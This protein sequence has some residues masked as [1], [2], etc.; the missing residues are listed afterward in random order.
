MLEI[1]V[2]QLLASRPFTAVVFYPKLPNHLKPGPTR[3]GLTYQVE[4]DLTSHPVQVL[5]A[6]NFYAY[7]AKHAKILQ[8]ENLITAASLTIH[9]HSGCRLGLGSLAIMFG[10][11]GRPER[12]QIIG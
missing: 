10:Q 5:S 12:M 9:E 7:F 1:C 2:G 6:P 3:L 8:T 11:P 4:P